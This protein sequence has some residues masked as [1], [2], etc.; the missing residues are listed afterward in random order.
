MANLGVNFIKNKYYRRKIGVY[1]THKN[2]KKVHI[3][4]S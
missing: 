3:N 2:G 4:K 1:Y